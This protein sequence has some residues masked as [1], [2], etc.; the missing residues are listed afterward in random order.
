MNWI[1]DTLW[2]L[3]RSRGA[4]GA[5][6]TKLEKALRAVEASMKPS[7]PP[8]PPVETLAAPNPNSNGKVVAQRGQSMQ[9]RYDAL[10]AD[11]KKVHNIRVRKWR[12]SMTG[13]AWIVTYENGKITRLLESPY[14]RGPMSCAIFLHEVGHHAIGFGTY[15]PRCLEELHAW[16]WSLN[17]M[18]RL[19]L[20]VT[21]AVEKRMHESLQY[22]IEKAMRR[23][24]KRLPIELEPYLPTAARRAFARQNST[25]AG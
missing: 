7:A 25:Q 18:H 19:G 4:S 9:E 5:K 17:E 6:P 16:K 20:N 21:P 10:V 2:D 14:P 3:V 24:L 23:G 22:A 11:M 12:K 1:A 13:C 8:S 15:S